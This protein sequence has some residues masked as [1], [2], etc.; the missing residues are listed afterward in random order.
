MVDAVIGRHIGYGRGIDALEAANVVSVLPGIGATLVVGVDAADGAE[1]VLGGA[2][3]ELVEPEIRGAFDDADSI[4]WH[5]SD[6]R[7][8]ASADGAIASP[9]LDDAVREIQ[10]Q[11]DRSAMACRP[12]LRMDFYAA[13]FLEHVRDLLRA[14]PIVWPSRGVAER[15]AARSRMPSCSV[16]ATCPYRC[17]QAGVSNRRAQWRADQPL[18]PT[19][20]FAGSAF[21]TRLS[22]PG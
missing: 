12:V 6:D 20:F 3:V 7:S 11:F 1:I 17:P 5:G 9:R 14:A 13:D 10:L 4:K 21:A 16:S 8:L 19:G 22:S 18:L 2:G 15:C